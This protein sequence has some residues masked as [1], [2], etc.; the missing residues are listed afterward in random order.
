MEGRKNKSPFTKY[1]TKHCFQCCD[2]F[3]DGENKEEV[4][5]ASAELDFTEESRQSAILR[6][7]QLRALWIDRAV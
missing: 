3:A 4:C 5:P 6:C 2:C 7:A 1:Y